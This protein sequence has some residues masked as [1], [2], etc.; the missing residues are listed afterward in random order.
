M[1]SAG[2][3]HVVRSILDFRQLSNSELRSLLGRSHRE[4]QWA[5]SSTRA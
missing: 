3:A 4:I 5:Q 1:V 2:Q